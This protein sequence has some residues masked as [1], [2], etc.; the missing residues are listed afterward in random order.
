MKLKFILTTIFAISV[1]FT[2]FPSLYSDSNLFSSVEAQQST[3]SDYEFHNY[4]EQ[5]IG[6]L[7]ASIINVQSNNSGLALAHALHPIEEI[8]EIINNRLIQT[9]ETLSKEFSS[10]LNNYVETVR[11]D[12]INKIITDKTELENL[13]ND[14]IA[15][16]ISLEKRN[17]RDY[18]LNVTAELITIASEEF[19]EAMLNGK[20]INLLEY[21]DGQQFINRAIMLLEESQPFLINDDKKYLDKLKEI[22]KDLDLQRDPS[23]VD[24]KVKDMICEIKKGFYC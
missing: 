2:I 7:D 17:N 5:M 23:G 1:Y 18:I 21:Q 9:N 10:K 4:L 14:A 3:L 22:G 16:S 12:N 19:N 15:Q 8:V 20:I 13:L 6:H 24:M 11:S